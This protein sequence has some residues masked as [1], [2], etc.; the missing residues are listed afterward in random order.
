MITLFLIGLA[1]IATFVMMPHG[2]NNC[3]ACGSDKLW[4]KTSGSICQN[5]GVSQ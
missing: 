3:V 4:S 2:V 1:V 5:C